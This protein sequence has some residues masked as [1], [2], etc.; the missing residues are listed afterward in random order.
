LLGKRTLPGAGRAVEQNDLTWLHLSVT[1]FATL[2][3]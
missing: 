3:A 2:H 1:P